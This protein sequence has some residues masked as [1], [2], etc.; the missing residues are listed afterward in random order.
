[1][2]GKVEELRAAS[3]AHTAEPEVEPGPQAAP[4]TPRKKD[5]RLALGLF[6]ALAA[7]AATLLVTDRDVLQ[8]LLSQGGA[9]AQDQQHEQAATAQRAWMQGVVERMTAIDATL[10][11]Q[12]EEITDLL[13]QLRTLQERNDHGL[14]DQ[15]QR[16]GRIAQVVETVQGLTQAQNDLK[17][18][19][20]AVARATQPPRLAAAQLAPP[21]PEQVEPPAPPFTVVSVDLWSE[22]PYVALSLAGAIDFLGLGD[23]LGGWQVQSIDLQ[24][25]QVVFIDKDGHPFMAEVQR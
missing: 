7:Y 9:A 5:R 12:G 13:A 8:Q 15:Q 11:Q 23:R 18:R 2:S 6:I 10:Q 4:R 22:R 24:A 17:R 16:D 3:A 1:M 25:R 21:Q 20:T 14:E 19:L